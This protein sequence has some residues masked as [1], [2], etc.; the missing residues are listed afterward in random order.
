MGFNPYADESASLNLDG[1][2]LENHVDHIAIYGQLSIN[3]DQQG[4]A[5]ALSL[6]AELMQIIAALQAI[7]LPER[8]KTA[9]AVTVKNPFA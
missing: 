3:K 7:E 4:L 6:Q 8:I 1:L 9:S 2:T 5:T